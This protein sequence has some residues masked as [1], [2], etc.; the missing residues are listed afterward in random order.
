MS[1][2]SRSIVNA[3]ALGWLAG[4]RAGEHASAVTSLPDVSELQL[5]LDAW[6]AWFIAAARQ[7]IEWTPRSQASVFFQ[8]D[9]RVGGAVIDKSYLVM[10]AAEQAGAQV[11][12]HK[13]VCRRPP[14]TIS[15]GR[16]SWSHMICIAY[17]GR[18]PARAPGPD[19]LPDAGFMPWS[20]AMGV[21]ACRVACTYLR[22]EIGARVIVDPF[23][24]RGTVL[25]V[26]NTLGLDA[27]G[28]ELSA[29]RCRAAR[30]LVVE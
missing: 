7:V 29:K 11:L 25:A 12:W 6:R 21:A 19:V 18:P 15:F 28:V 17:E 8:S 5:P 14:G 30:A 23:C 16:P 10:R 22:D 27:I 20:R 3:D 9:V 24:G 13:I 4:N 1:Q 2:P 26:A